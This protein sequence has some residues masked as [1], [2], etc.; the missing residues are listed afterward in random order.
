MLEKRYWLDAFFLKLVDIGDYF[1]RFM[2]SF[3]F[4][5]L[6]QL[7]IDGW[8]WLTLKLSK[9]QG[10]IDDHVVDAALNATGA[11]TM[12]AGR[13]TRLTQTGLIQN[14]LFFVAVAVSIFG[15]SRSQAFR[16]TKHVTMSL[17]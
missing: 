10:W 3:D 15:R 2:F 13:L 9:L 12:S 4:N 17:S 16:R 6:D 8:A 14:Y 1:G 5:F 11:L 7:V